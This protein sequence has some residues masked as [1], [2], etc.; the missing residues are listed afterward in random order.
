M[1]T[2]RIFL[3][4]ATGVIG[5][6]V[7]PL[8]VALDH[9]VTALVHRPQSRAEIERAGAV[10]VRVDLFA[11]DALQRAVAGHDAVINLATHLPAG[12]R[13]FLPGAWAENDRIRRV[14]SANLVDAA[15][16][17]GVTRFIQESFAPAY[18]D[19]GE[20][21]IDERT[22][23]A[24]VRLNRSLVDAERSAQRF[25]GGA[26]TGVVLRFA[27]FY[28]PDSWFTR[29][30]IRY[31]RRGFVPM[32]GAAESYISSVSHDDAA[33][34][35]VGAL[36]A[37][38]GTYNVA[39]DEPMRR[40]AFVGTLAEVLRVGAPRLAPPWTKHLFGSLGEMLA[41][42]VRVSN[43][44]LREECAWVPRYPSMREGWRA[45]AAAIP[46]GELRA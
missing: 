18:P 12:W 14:A 28:G 27:A 34:A 23:L 46:P 1:A 43:R 35:V 38:A 33:T 40:R 41:R 7:L 22:S 16:T 31:V 36:L 13:M 45:V 26:R 25:S 30:L 24:P 9:G 21:W 8:L 42:S 29:D 44:K 39:D 3:T 20:A 4:G 37:R 11:R 19:R 6:R 15:I 10:P 5:R 17:G 2:M 32:P